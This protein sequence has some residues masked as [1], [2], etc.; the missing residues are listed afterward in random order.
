MRSKLDASQK[1]SVNEL[2]LGSRERLDLPDCRAV[3]FPSLWTEPLGMVVYEAYEQG[4]PV[5]ASDLG[6]LKAVITDGQTGR[7]I[8]AGNQPAW[9]VAF[10]P[11]IAQP[12]MSRQWAN[13][14]GN[15]STKKFLRPRGTGSSTRLFGK[16]CREFQETKYY[17]CR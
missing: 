6:G 14:D 11:F 10:Q 4:R 9:V 1:A 8:E 5:L 15:G 16:R 12:E 7:L 3:R 2:E 17:R 13:A